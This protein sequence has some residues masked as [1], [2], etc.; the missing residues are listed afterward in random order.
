MKINNEKKFILVL[1]ILSLVVKLGIAPIYVDPPDYPH[2]FPRY[3]DSA[4]TL[5][6]GKNPYVDY[7]PEMGPSNYGPLYIVLMASWIGIFGEDYTLLKFPSILVDTLSVILIFYIVKNLVN[8]EAAKYASVAYLF[9]WVSLYFS[10]IEG[11][12]DIF[13]LF[14]LLIS[15][16]YVIKSKPNLHF[17]AIFLGI[18]IGFK[19]M[20]LVLFLPLVI[21]YILQRKGIRDVLIYVSILAATL[22]IINLPFFITAGSKI[23]HPYILGASLPMFG[24]SIPNILNM[25]INYLTLDDWT[26]TL[27]YQNP[28]LDKLA[29]PM[30]LLAY[31]LVGLYVLKYKMENKERELVRNICLFTVATF[32]F[33]R[34][35]Y[36]VI[37]IV[38][39]AIILFAYKYKEKFR[40]SNHEIYGIILVLLSL[41]IYSYIYRWRIEYS[42]LQR[43]LMIIGLFM[44]FFGTYLTLIKSE[45]RLSWS[46]AV[47]SSAAYYTMQADLLRLLAP[48]IPLF[49]DYR[50]AWGAYA[51]GVTIIFVCSML[52]LF[53]EIHYKISKTERV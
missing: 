6:Q 47:F 39:F 17:S 18:S 30:I 4:R 15:L 41:I 46:F 1:F 44:S 9:S 20:P 43:L 10:A 7:S 3:L 19:F 37:W 36:D 50:I 21:Y 23:L 11:D 35:A 52:F 53:Y 24:L 16:W 32:L 12:D 34:A 2:D 27:V 48:V 51:F 31:L 45:F 42:M 5:L 28:F 49:R 40:I 33:A 25:L 22:G 8:S 14:F 29:F 26:Q 13:W 38:P